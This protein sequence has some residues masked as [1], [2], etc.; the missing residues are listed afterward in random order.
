MLPLGMACLK[1]RVD[2]WRCHGICETPHQI[3]FSADS[4]NSPKLSLRAKRSNLDFQT[5]Q[6]VRLLR[7]ARNDRIKDAAASYLPFGLI[8]SVC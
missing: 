6:I 1:S 5:R 3:W 2:I 8:I 7:F 4:V